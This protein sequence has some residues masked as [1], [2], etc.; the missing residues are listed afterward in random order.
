VRGDND[1]AGGLRRALIAAR[2]P[3]DETRIAGTKTFVEQHL[4][5]IAVD[6]AKSRRPRMPAE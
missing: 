2:S 3:L 4:G 1:D 6:M 5:L